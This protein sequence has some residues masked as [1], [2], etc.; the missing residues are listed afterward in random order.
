MRPPEDEEDDSADGK[1]GGQ[2]DEDVINTIGF[3]L[4]GEHGDQEG[5]SARQQDESE[6]EE[7]RCGRALREPLQLVLLHH[8]DFQVAGSA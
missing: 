1:H 2:D 3:D 6:V 5:N 8:V 7:K 4:G